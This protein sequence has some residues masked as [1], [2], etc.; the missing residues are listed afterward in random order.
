M[1]SVVGI[2]E[3][4][5]L[6]LEVGDVEVVVYHEGH[7]EISFGLPE[8]MD[9]FVLSVSELTEI[10]QFVEKHGE[11]SIQPELVRE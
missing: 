6:S 11:V 3:R 1:A 7:V 4:H 8:R 9:N 10:V 5:K 2:S